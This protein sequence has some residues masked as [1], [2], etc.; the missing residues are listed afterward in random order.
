MIGFNFID[1]NNDS[2]V[3]IVTSITPNYHGYMIQLHQNMG[4]NTFKDVTVDLVSNYNGILGGLD[5]N[6]VDGDFP[7]FY[8]I[9]PYDY[10]GDG[11]LDLVPHK[12]AC[13]NAYKY[14]KNV[15]WEFNGGK[16]LL[17]K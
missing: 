14:S 7:H 5:K 12:V 9:R 13:W 16:F 17:R 15:Y 6:G 11:D 8:A 3:D 4:N 1:F 2:K 10:D